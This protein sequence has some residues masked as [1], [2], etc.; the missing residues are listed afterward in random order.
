MKNQI[1]PTTR[2]KSRARAFA[3]GGLGWVIAALRLLPA[4]AGVEPPSPPVLVPPVPAEWALNLQHT[5]ALA[6]TA[7][8]TNHPTIRVLYWGLSFTWGAWWWTTA[9]SLRAHYP[10]VDWQIEN[11][12]M[13]GH[14]VEALRPLAES[15]VYPYR[16]D[17]IIFHAS[18]NKEDF[19]EMVRQM[20]TRTTADILM[21]GNHVRWPVELN[22]LGFVGEPPEESALWYQNVWF[23][24]LA[25]T[26]GMAYADVRQPWLVHIK[27]TGLGVSAFLGEDGVH[28]NDEGARVMG[29]F[30]LPYFKPPQLLPRLDPWSC[31]RVR[32]LV[33]GRD[34]QWADGRARVTFRGNRVEALGPSGLP[35]RCR[36]RID[37]KPVSAHA[38]AYYAD[39]CS[40]WPG[41]WVP[42]ALELGMAKPVLEQTWLFTITE[43]LPQGHNF[44]FRVSGSVSGFEGEGSTLQRFDSRSGSAFLEPA[45][46]NLY[47]YWGG[48]IY[49]GFQFSIATHFAGIDQTDAFPS[50]PAGRHP[51]ITLC[52]GLADVEHVLELEALDATAANLTALRIYHPSGADMGGEPGQISCLVAADQTAI[53]SATSGESPRVEVTSELGGVWQKAPEGA[54]I[55]ADNH[56]RRVQWEPNSTPARFFRWR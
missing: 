39:L 56:G 19:I 4:P 3:I 31:G 32:T 48:E 34:L 25:R 52:S 17:L 42:V 35:W 29:L 38:G 47:R 26:Y 41:T 37:G 44:K 21:F 24:D 33:A 27:R 50:V 53:V 49:P 46:W 28:L 7:S 1:L 12:A 22:D 43:L 15:Q 5:F 13:S 18:G 51:T 55:Q 36:V 30:L 23:P 14:T 54:N 45:M 11:H 40:G 9:Q 6:E 2:H 16:P 10:N 8:A 20:R